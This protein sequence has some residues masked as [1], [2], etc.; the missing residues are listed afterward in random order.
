MI[1]KYQIT[2]QKDYYNQIA[3]DF[4]QKFERENTN[5][6]Y[7]IQEIGDIFAKHL[8]LTEKKQISI[9]E[10]GGGTGIHAFHFLQSYASFIASF[11]INDL[12]GE[13]L[14]VAKKRLI[15]FDNLITYHC[16]A[17]EEIATEKIYNGIY[18]SGSMHH[19][20]NPAVAIHIMK[21]LLEP[22]GI[23]VICEPIV[24]NPVNFIKAIIKKEEWG[25]FNVT[26][27]F[28]ENNLKKNELEIIE[29]RVLHY[30]SDNRIIKS[31][32][33]HKT[34]ERIKIFDNFGVMFLIA[35][36]NHK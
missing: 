5:H 27:K 29:N 28:I 24:F 22:D 4:D 20:S 10:I 32:L 25:Q 35:A 34:L 16:G 19:F 7:K 8:F 6:L 23:I 17:A 30:K 12:S 18:I 21:K 26:R 2:N 1:D 31:V 3:S 36:K 33:P 9:F 13:M 15:Q 14:K 11:T